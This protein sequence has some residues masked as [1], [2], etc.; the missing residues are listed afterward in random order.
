MEITPDFS[1]AV[2]LAEGQVPDGTYK[3]RVV[4]VELKDSKAGNKYLNWKLE[5]FGAEGEV[6]R[7]NNW[8]VFHRT[9][10]SGKG[11]GMLKS[12]V[13]A[14]TGEELQGNLNTDA[15]LGK[16]LTATLKTEINPQSGEPS[17]FPTVKAVK[18]IA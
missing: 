4:G 6:A 10:I 8:K 15:I 2:E 5:I 17:S 18:A 16:E 14:A 13:K 7:Y 11:A 12:F 9:M 1:E 3:V